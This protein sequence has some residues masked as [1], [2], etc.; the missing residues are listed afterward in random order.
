MIGAFLLLL[1]LAGIALSQPRLA[2]D[3]SGEWRASV[4]STRRGEPAARLRKTVELPADAGVRDLMLILGAVRQRSAVYVS[5]HHLATVG[6]SASHSA[7]QLRRPRVFPV[8]AHALEVEKGRRGSI[9][10]RRGSPPDSPSSLWMAPGEGLNAAD[11]SSQRIRSSSSFRARSIAWALGCAS[12]ADSRKSTSMASPVTRML[13]A[14]VS[15]CESCRVSGA[16][17]T[18]RRKS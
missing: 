11:T 8:P 15:M 2:I 5:R 12:F 4:N 1:G 3:S 13:V 14:T 18:V 9:E 6:S 7:T 17:L 16:T 10:L